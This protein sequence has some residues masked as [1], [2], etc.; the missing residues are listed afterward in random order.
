MADSVRIA[1]ALVVEKWAKGDGRRETEEA[2]DVEV[3]AEV[4]PLGR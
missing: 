3:S 2:R 4:D 1:I